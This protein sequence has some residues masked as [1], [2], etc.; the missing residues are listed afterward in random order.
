MKKIIQQEIITCYCDLCNEEVTGGFFGDINLEVVKSEDRTEVIA[1]ELC[2]DCAEKVYKY[3]KR[4][5]KS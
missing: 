5:K 4:V 1:L 2:L 3:I